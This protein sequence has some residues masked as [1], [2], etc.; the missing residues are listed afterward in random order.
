MKRLITACLV[1]PTAALF[2]VMTA[3]HGLH[4]TAAAAACV[5]QGGLSFSAALLLG[6]SPLAFRR[7]PQPEPTAPAALA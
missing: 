5:V 1:A 2:G 7:A 3:R 4:D 6:L